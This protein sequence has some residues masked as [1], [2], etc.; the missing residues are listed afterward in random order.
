MT[1]KFWLEFAMQDAERR[2][3]TALKPL[4]ETLARATSS[5]RTADWNSDA[6]DEGDDPR[7][8][9]GR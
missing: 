4:L 9:D 6:S 2:S 7:V 1:I 5:L 3:L 8:P